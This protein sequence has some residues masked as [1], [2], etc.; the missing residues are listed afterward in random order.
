MGWTPLGSGRAAE[1]RR[2]SPSSTGSHAT[3]RR[4][5]AKSYDA[6][7]NVRRARALAGEPAFRMSLLSPGLVR[8]CAGACAGLS[9]F[10]HSR[11]GAALGAGPCIAARRVHVLR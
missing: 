4:E 8:A 3:P 6:V 9:T 11:R 10:V 7:M 1:L 5:R 2:F